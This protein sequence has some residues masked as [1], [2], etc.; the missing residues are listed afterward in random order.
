M[1]SMKNMDAERVNTVVA[2]ANALTSRWAR[3]ACQGGSSVFSGAGAWPLLAILAQ[4]AG[5]VARDE[6]EHAVGIEAS[7][8]IAAAKELMDSMTSSVKLALGLW[9][10][11]TFPIKDEWRR[12]VPADSWGELRHDG[13]DQ[14]R[15]DQWADDRT[16]GLIKSMPI[17][18]EKATLFVLASALMVRTEWQS[19]FEFE[20]V[21]RESAS[22][23]L[24]GSWIQPAGLSMLTRSTRAL[25]ELLVSHKAE[26]PMTLAEVRG[27]NDISIWLAMGEEG[28]SPAEVIAHAIEIV[29]NPTGY[30]LGSSLQE[31]DTAPGVTAATV[32]DAINEIPILRV[33]T[34]PFHLTMVHDLL[35]HADV[36]GL[37]A[38]ADQTEGHFPEISS[39]PM[40]VSEAKQS[41]TAKFSA[42]GFEAAAITAISGV[43]FAMPRGE[44]EKFRRMEIT[45]TF[46]RP[47]AFVAVH[48]PSRMVLVA[49]WVAE[50]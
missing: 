18:V 42:E 37:K 40:A 17:K 36:F 28:A 11:S 30:R 31:G 23:D 44:P 49:G 39:T 35:E 27:N 29:E 5:G 22:A 10:A 3:Q 43:M 12:R 33:K 20:F 34:V 48:R 32:D 50:P 8:G 24:T 25:D 45:A 4:G 21:G 16:D 7:H 38:A 47:F 1:A 41:V 6:L 46:D 14:A 15:L 26:T 19:P 13:S 2:R 9:V